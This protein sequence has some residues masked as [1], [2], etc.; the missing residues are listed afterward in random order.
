[1]LLESDSPKTGADLTP[2]DYNTEGELTNKSAEVKL[3][4]GAASKAEQFIQNKQY[5]LFG[6]ILTYFFKA[7]VQCLYSKIHT[8]WNL[9]YNASQSQKL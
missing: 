6:V 4:L 5:A 8:F 1:M 2:K 9:M 7:L 3:V